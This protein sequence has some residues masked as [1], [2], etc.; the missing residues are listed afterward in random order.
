MANEVQLPYFQTRTL[1]YLLRNSGG[2]I[3][4][5]ANAAF[6]NYLPASYADYVIPMTEQGDSG[7]YAGAMVIGSPTGLYQ[8]EIREQTGG[9][10]DA[11]PAVDPTAGFGTLPWN[12]TAQSSAFMVS[13][14]QAVAGNAA[15]ASELYTMI[16]HYTGGT[17]TIEVCN[18][19]N[20]VTI[21]ATVTAIA[22]S[23]ISGTSFAVNTG[24]RPLNSGAFT[25]GQITATTIQLSTI[26]T[27]WA[28]IT[29]G[30]RIYITYGASPTTGS[31]GQ[32]RTVVSKDNGTGI[33]TFSPPLLGNTA[34][35]GEWAIVTG[36]AEM[37]L[38]KTAWNTANPTTIGGQI[39]APISGIAAAVWAFVVEGATTA[40]QIM[41]GIAGFAM[42]KAS[43]GGA[44]PVRF[45]DLA[46]TKNRIDMTVD[47]SGNRTAVAR[48]LS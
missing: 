27:Y 23:G 17:F 2:E 33:V 19:V 26:S 31:S 7:Y 11:N 4:N 32:W 46:D 41:R 39:D 21:V 34:L 24:L 47:A 5:G 20:T 3:W 37:A 14:I 8:V 13:D 1:Y 28:Y 38:D 25:A 40:V 35:A 22:T 48:D 10:P 9:A 30:S 18:T 6:E 42:G 45:R 16:S 44:G 12:S 15:S 43:G 36:I 29:A